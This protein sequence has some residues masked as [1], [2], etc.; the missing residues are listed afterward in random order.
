MVEIMVYSLKVIVRL[1]TTLFLV[2]VGGFFTWSE[3]HNILRIAELGK[4]EESEQ[5]GSKANFIL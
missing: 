3:Q 1:Y 4:E 5:A 2:L